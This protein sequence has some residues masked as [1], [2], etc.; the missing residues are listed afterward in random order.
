MHLKVLL[1]ELLKCVV[2]SSAAVFFAVLT[3]RSKHDTTDSNQNDTTTITQFAT[4]MHLKV[5]LHEFLQRI[6]IPSAAVR[7]TVLIQHSSSTRHR[8]NRT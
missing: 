8:P 2:V 5:L 4:S 7:G 6:V 3:E 1:H